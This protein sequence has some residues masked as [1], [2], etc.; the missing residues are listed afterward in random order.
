VFCASA[1]GNSSILEF[2]LIF[3]DVLLFINNESLFFLFFPIFKT[4]KQVEIND[5]DYHRAR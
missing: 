2:L 5:A 1:R 4:V 3:L